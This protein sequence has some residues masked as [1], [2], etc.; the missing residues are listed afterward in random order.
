MNSISK[1]RKLTFGTGALRDGEYL[2][3]YG[4]D[5]DKRPT[6]RGRYLIVGRARAAAEDFATWRF[7]RDGRWDNDYRRARMVRGVASELSFRICRLQ[8]IRAG[9]YRRRPFASHPGADRRG[10]VGTVVGGDDALPVPRIELGQEDLLLR[11][12]GPSLAG[13]RR[14]TGY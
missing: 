6:R 5:D 12:E 14:R 1:E 13:G 11:G 2:Y 7:Y 9:V 8:A 10:A 3:L 4:T